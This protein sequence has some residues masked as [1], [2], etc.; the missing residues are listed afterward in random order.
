MQGKNDDEITIEC[1]IELIS[2]KK[3]SIIT[4]SGKIRSENITSLN[5]EIQNI[6]EDEVYNCIMN[7]E[8]LRYINSTGI[9]MILTIQKTVEQNG[10]KLLLVSPSE[11]VHELL[12]LTNL[13]DHF[14]IHE[15]MSSARQYFSKAGNETKN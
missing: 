11:F 5:K 2:Q 15:N 9:A 3:V 10:G 4:L 14:E 1:S 7:I 13:I 6:F 8:K 12:V